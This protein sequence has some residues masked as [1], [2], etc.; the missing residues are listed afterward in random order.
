MALSRP[1]SLN[2]A[3]GDLAAGRMAVRMRRVEVAE[4]QPQAGKLHTA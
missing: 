4:L 2:E 1:I 3:A